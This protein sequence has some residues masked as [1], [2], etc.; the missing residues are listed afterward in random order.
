MLCLWRSHFNIPCGCI[1]LTSLPLPLS[2][3]TTTWLVR[4]KNCLGQKLTKAVTSYY[5][6]FLCCKHREGEV[7]VSKG[8]ILHIQGTQPSS[9]THISDFTSS[10]PRKGLL[11]TLVTTLEGTTC[12]RVTG[13][14][15]TLVITRAGEACTSRW[16]GKKEVKTC[17]P[18]WKIS[19][20]PC[21]MCS[22][23]LLL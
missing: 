15:L 19:S 5:S 18:G 1:P 23:A 22:P 12:S 20:L 21:S 6:N 2:F 14:H 17:G 13:S 9:E 10:S 11:G 3:R 16:M 8:A 7:L 4:A